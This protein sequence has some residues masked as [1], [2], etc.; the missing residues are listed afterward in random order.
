MIF[1]IMLLLGCDIGTDSPNQLSG[2]DQ[3]Q[4]GQGTAKTVE[5]E[6]SSSGLLTEKERQDAK[7][8]QAASY[9]E[10][11]SERKR[12]MTSIDDEPQEPAPNPLENPTIEIPEHWAHLFPEKEVWA[13]TKN[14]QVIIGGQ[15]VL[16]RGPL[17]MFI[18]PGGSGKEHESIIA[19]NALSSEVHA[20]LMAIDCQPGKSASWNPTYVPAH[21]PQIE[22][23]IKWRDKDS[24]EVKSMSARDWIRNVQTKKRMAADFVFGGSLMYKDPDSGQNYYM[25]DSGELICLSNFSTATIDI[26]VPSS[27]DNFDLLFEAFHENIPPLGTHVYAFLKPGKMIEKAAETK[28][29]ETKAA[30]TEATETKKSEDQTK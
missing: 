17:E 2:S 16:S 3:T 25:G 4:Q 22:V 26:N 12:V 23:E 11:K 9:T 5:Q 6:A 15:I 27:Q 13:D 1:L 28:A 20:A 18:C 8:A 19:A 30:K 7:S 14:K 10:D 21:G 29:P 24:N